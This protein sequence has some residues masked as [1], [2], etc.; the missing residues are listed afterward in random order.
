[1][2]QVENLK[3]VTIANGKNWIYPQANPKVQTSHAD[4]RSCIISG[5][6]VEYFSSYAWF[7]LV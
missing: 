5:L 2:T 7:D 6:Q 3:S 1:M 4:Q